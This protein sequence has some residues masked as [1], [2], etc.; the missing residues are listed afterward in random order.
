MKML[1]TLLPYKDGIY[2]IT[3]FATSATFQTYEEAFRRTIGS[4]AFKN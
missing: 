3:C 2:A 1:G 4:F